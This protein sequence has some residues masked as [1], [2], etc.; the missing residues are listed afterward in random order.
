MRV[1]A[2]SRHGAAQAEGFSLHAGLDIQPARMMGIG[3]SV[4][5]LK[6]GWYA[7][8]ARPALIAIA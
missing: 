7:V 1:G 5:R 6:A 2:S 8:R 3:D 4:G